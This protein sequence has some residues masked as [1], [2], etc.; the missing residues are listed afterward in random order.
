MEGLNWDELSIC[1][2]SRLPA[3]SDAL[4]FCSASLVRNP[5]SLHCLSSWFLQGHQGVLQ[6]VAATF[7]QH[8]WTTRYHSTTIIMS[9]IISWVISYHTHTVSIHIHTVSIS[10]PYLYNICNIYIYINII[11]YL[12]P[13]TYSIT[14]YHIVSYR[15][16]SII[17]LYLRRRDTRMGNVEKKYWEHLGAQGWSGNKS[18]RINGQP[19]CIRFQKA[20]KVSWAQLNH[21]HWS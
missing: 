12:H 9:D 20:G 5:Q 1:C 7:P 15:F 13:Y 8:V 2:S 16:I 21:A 17:A 4:S 11:L 14:A 6:Q 18:G 19:L 10:N 3:W